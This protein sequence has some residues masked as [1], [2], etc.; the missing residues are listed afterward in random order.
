MNKKNELRKTI[1]NECASLDFTYRKVAAQLL[2]EIA[3]PLLLKVHKIAIYHATANEIQLDFLIEDALNCRK[4]LFQ[5]ISYMDS[6]IMHFDCYNKA[7]PHIFYP[8]NY[9]LE[10]E[11]QWYNLELIFLPLVAVD[12]L[13][14]RLGKGGGYYDATLSGIL[15]KKERPILC[16]VGF[17]CQLID[18]VP[19]NKWDIPLNYFLSEKQLIKF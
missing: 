19:T 2:V 8:N 18:R 1:S 9:R 6:K 3:K 4:E 12:K 14:Y 17:A 7:S 13:G 10:C 15:D 11:V 5:P 16:G